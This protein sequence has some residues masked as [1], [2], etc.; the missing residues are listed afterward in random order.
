MMKVDNNTIL[1]FLLGGKCECVILNKKS[2]NKFNFRLSLAKDS[3]SMYFIYTTIN[4]VSNA[5]AGFVRVE[6]GAYV[7]KQGTKGLMSEDDMPI[8]ALMYV[9]KHHDK[10][11]SDVEVLHVGKC[12]RC[13]RKLTNPDSIH[14]GLGPECVK[15]VRAIVGG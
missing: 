2:G 4:G 1:E 5:Y 12:A 11:H 15:K 13:G 3:K 6:N 9:L 10:L 7:Y 14:S 8:K